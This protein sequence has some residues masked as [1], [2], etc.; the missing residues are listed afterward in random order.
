[1]ANDL[2]FR[3][4]A[5]LT[6]IKGALAQLR[7]EFARTG[8]AGRNVGAGI[9]SGGAGALRT[10]GQLV[11][12]VATLA[13]ALT[14]IGRADSLTQLNGRLRL[15]T[16]S[17]EEFERAQEALFQQAQRTRSEL[18]ATVT[19]YTQIANAT[20]DAGVGQEVLLSVV[21]TI[22][23]AVQLSGASTQAAE[24]ALV[25]LGQGLA[26]GALRGEEL[27]SILEQTPALADAIAKGLGITRGELRRYGEE[28]KLTAEAVIGALQSQGAE[29]A[30]Q[31]QSLP[32]TVG[33]ATTLVQNAFTRIIGAFDQASG[34]TSGLAG[35]IKSLAD[36]LSSD[37]VIGAVIEFAQI[38]GDT[39]GQIVDDFREAVRIIEDG[40]R[41]LT[42]STEGLVSLIVRAIKELPANVRTAVRIA[43]ITFAGMVDAF[44]ADIRF[45]RDAIVA[46]F[47]DDTIDAALQRRNARVRAAG[48]TVRDLVTEEVEANRRLVAE[49]QQT[50]EQARQARERA[51]QTS[52]RTGRGTFTN[53]PS[54]QQ[55]SEA[56]A[57]AQAKADAEEK[58]QKDSAARQLS[59]L[60][61]LYDDATL[62]ARDYFAAREAVELASIERS[63]ANERTRLGTATS[64]DRVKILADIQVLENQKLDI[65]RRAARDR[66]QAERDID[67]QL[68]QARVTE[69]ENAGRT[70]DAARLRAEAQFRDLLR[71]LEAEG[72]AAGANLIRGLIDTEVARARFDEIRR[73]F[74]RV[75]SGL[76]ARQQALADQRNA[77][78]ISPDAAAAG[79]QQAREQAI[80]QL[81]R[82]N[83]ELQTLAQSTNDPRIVEGAEESTRAL[84][85]L[86]TDGAVGLDRALIDLRASLAN[87]EAN[88]A[89]QAVGA[90]V[91]ALTGL[92]EG[93]IDGTKSGSEALRDFVAGFVRS[94]AQ[95]AARALATFLV[96]QTLDAIFPGLG[97]TVAATGGTI[98]AGVRHSGGMAGGGPRRQVPAW[99]F[100]AAPRFHNGG[101]VGLKPGEVP[102]VLQTGERV[103]NRAETADYNAGRSGGSTRIVNVL[104]PDLI[105]DGMSSAAGERV[106]LNVIERNAAGIKQRLG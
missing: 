1:M 6:E 15:V 35:A 13:T 57:L 22:N 69:L 94:M 48:E 68:E 9:Q 89:S 74:E 16:Q 64:A 34:A 59:I 96:L 79:T 98:G 20:K 81:Q 82:L 45:L 28:G 55:I 23:Q 40:T 36:F 70:A 63:I 54:Q 18:G 5:E 77:G 66:A 99:L 90:G 67:R 71:R 44:T 91:D 8:D 37:E 39:I 87:L 27:N 78:A 86:A 29:V 104:S 61:D 2:E 49:A 46:I 41:D 12:G 76:A 47:T 97:R 75:Q 72:N 106:I 43:V 50:A 84:Q 92:F 95:I 62:A 30:K 88:F 31:F 33:Q 3:I 56:R 105:T 24:A 38:W 73:E 101:M 51:R 103:L 14:L 7:Q 60:S 26:S 65:A 42:G 58:I 80:A 83:A 93:L 100:A 53:R 52:N 19:L 21:E 17:T 85:R 102:A 10:V 25:Q 32:L 4:G 11:A